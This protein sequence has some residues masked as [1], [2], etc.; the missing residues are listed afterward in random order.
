MLE[1]VW[2]V[3]HGVSPRHTFNALTVEQETGTHLLVPM[4]SQ[5]TEV[6]L[7]KSG[8][9]GL[10]F[11]SP[12][13]LRVGFLTVRYVSFLSRNNQNMPSKKCLACFDYGIC[14]CASARATV[15]T[16]HFL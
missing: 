16:M 14:L 12:R 7:P 13:V 11:T 10:A 4:Y 1:A 6:L 15:V 2:R 8:Q 3:A 9:E 5:P